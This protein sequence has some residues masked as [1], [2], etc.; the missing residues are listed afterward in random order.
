MYKTK[1]TEKLFRFAEKHRTADTE[2][3]F[4]KQWTFGFFI[5]WRRWMEEK[6]RKT[7]IVCMCA[8]REQFN[9]ISQHTFST[10][11]SIADSETI[12]PFCVGCAHCSSTATTACFHPFLADID[13]TDKK[14]KN[15]MK[16]LVSAT[17]LQHPANR[18]TK[19]VVDMAN[20]P[21][22]QLCNCVHKHMANGRQNRC[23]LAKEW[24]IW[25]VF[26][27]CVRV[28]AIN[29]GF[30]EPKTLAYRSKIFVHWAAVGAVGDR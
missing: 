8:A 19:S 22:R 2:R 27:D 23:R 10:F 11:H 7:A 4:S 13:K 24:I 20:M 26:V 25:I 21:T 14:H 6:E 3:N 28:P 1:R 29:F 12:L 15:I 18:R 9:I 5:G 30:N 16:Q 17:N